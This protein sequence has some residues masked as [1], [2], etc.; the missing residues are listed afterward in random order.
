MTAPTPCGASLNDV[1]HSAPKRSESEFHRVSIIHGETIALLTHR[2]LLQA[3]TLCVATARMDVLNLLNSQCTM[4]P[5]GYI[6]PDPNAKYRNAIAAFA[7]NR[8]GGA[9]DMNPIDAA[10]ADVSPMPA[11]RSGRCAA[12]MVAARA[13]NYPWRST[14]AGMTRADAK[15][16]IARESDTVRRKTLLAEQVRENAVIRD[17]LRK[18]PKAHRPGA[19]GCAH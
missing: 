16:L 5:S 17:V 7:D 8:G 12:R 19:N 14:F 15:R 10:D 3:R 1:R 4:R 18:K 6:A 2:F 11:C 9:D 13:L